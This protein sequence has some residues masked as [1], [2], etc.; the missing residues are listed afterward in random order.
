[1]QTTTMPVMRTTVAD[2]AERYG[3]AAGIRDNSA[4]QYAITA[5]LFERWAGRPVLLE[6]LNEQTVGRWLRDYGQAVAP[7][8]VRSKRNQLIAL[9]RAAADEHLCEPPRR[10]VR[11]AKVPWVP[12]QA[13]TVDEVRRLLAAAGRLKRRHRCGLPRSEWFDLAIRL[14]FSDI[15]G[16]RWCKVQSKTGRPASGRLAPGT[17]AAI[18]A[19]RARLPRDVVCPWPATQNAFTG[20]VR[21]LVRLADIRPGTWKWIRRGAASNVEGKAPGAGMA[22]RQ[23]GHAPGSK[24]AELNYLDPAVV[25]TGAPAVHPDDLAGDPP[26]D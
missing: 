19:S 6:E 12:R 1:M 11:I 22:A 17:V 20:Q 18:A 15:T 26:T 2:Y 16:D 14:R 7:T 10:R 9:W 24:V 5:A 3:S 23:L 25:A 13:W 8:T 21:R 4:R